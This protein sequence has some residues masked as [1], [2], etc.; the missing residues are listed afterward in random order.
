MAGE[1]PV[2]FVFTGGHP[3]CICFLVPILMTDA[4]FA[5]YQKLVMAGLD[6][7]EEVAKIAKR[8]TSIPASATT[9]LNTNAEKIMNLKSQP[10]FW[11]NNL[12]Y[13]PQISGQ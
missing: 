12:K 2:D 13:M 8:I 3:F 7:P 11:A 10:Y 6:T 1:Y 9:W 4:Q 5:A